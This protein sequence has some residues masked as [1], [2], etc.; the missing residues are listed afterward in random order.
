MK[1]KNILGK[2]RLDSG[3]YEGEKSRGKCT[4]RLVDP[5]QTERR[6]ENHRVKWPPFLQ[7]RQLSTLE[8]GAINDDDDIYI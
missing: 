5:K 3:K 8:A 4:I 1:E 6:A 7:C 2:I